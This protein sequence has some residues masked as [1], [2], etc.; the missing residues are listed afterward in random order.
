MTDDVP[1]FCIRSA[2]GHRFATWSKPGLSVVVLDRLNCYRTMAVFHT[3]A[4]RNGRRRS[5]A[6]VYRL[7]RATAARLNHKDRQAAASAL[8]DAESTLRPY[9]AAG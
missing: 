7:A 9:L 2:R 3:D 8:S 4:V 5:D 6:E 1:R